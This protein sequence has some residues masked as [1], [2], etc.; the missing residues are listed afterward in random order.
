MKRILVIGNGFDIAH[1]LPTRY[2]NFLYACASITGKI[3]YLDG[4]DGAKVD[5]KVIL[6]FKKQLTKND[7]ENMN[8]NCWINYFFQRIFNMKHNWIDF[9]QE[10]KNVCNISD[11]NKKF[12]IRRDEDAIRKFSCF[13]TT[14]FL[15]TSY[16][17]DITLMI[18][19][20]AT[21]KSILKKF[22][23]VINEIS[24]KCYSKDVLDFCPDEIFSYNY[25]TTFERIYGMNN[26]YYHG[27]FD[28]NIVLGIDAVDSDNHEYDD[29]TKTIQRMKSGTSINIDSM[30][31]EDSEVLF[32]GLSFGMEDIDSIK[33]IINKA[34]KVYITYYNDADKD[35]KIDNLAYYYDKPNLED[36]YTTKIHFIHQ[37]KM[38]KES[39]KNIANRRMVFSIIDNKEVNSINSNEIKN[40]LINDYVG[41]RHF[42]KLLKGFLDYHNFNDEEQEIISKNFD[43]R[44]NQT[45][46]SQNEKEKLADE[47]YDK[48]KI[49][50]IR[51]AKL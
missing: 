32:F 5:E 22:I 14:D 38:I 2:T 37:E 31:G 47:L 1:G 13:M 41:I 23:K 18:N 6:N 51:M 35:A 29:F 10:I 48:F 28:S 11:G 43:E 45:Y 33:K 50:V 49:P 7:L 46:I 3:S 39:I 21:L 26:Y 36:L 27:K 9:E 20:L 19:H 15:G 16:T 8:N 42:P 30:L 24:I 25:S 17:F 34:I 12:N 44:F 4:I 40:V